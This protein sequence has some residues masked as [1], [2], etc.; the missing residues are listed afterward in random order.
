M[1]TTLP[2]IP[3]LVV[4]PNLTTEERKRY[5]KDYY[6]AHINKSRREEILPWPILDPMPTGFTDF[7][8]DPSVGTRSSMSAA[9]YKAALKAQRHAR[10]QSSAVI[11]DQHRADNP[12]YS[13]ALDDYRQRVIAYYREAG[14]PYYDMEPDDK[15][16]ELNKLLM[17]D[18][19]S[20]IQGDDVGQSMHGLSLAWVYFKHSWGVQC[21]KMKTAKEVFEDDALFEKAL[22]KR[23]KFGVYVS[24]SGVRKALRSFSGAQAVS[25][26]RPTAAAAIYD[27]FLS[28]VAEGEG[29]TW[30][31]SSGFGGRLLGAMA[32]RKVGTYIGTDPSTPTMNGLRD[33]E[34]ELLPLLYK[35]DPTRNPLKVELHQ[36]G[37]EDYNPEPE[38]ID[39]CFTS[40]PYFDTEKYTDEPTQSYIKFKGRDAW[41]NE[42]MRKTLDNC[43]KG[44][45]PNGHLVVNIADVKSYVTLNT[46]FVERAEKCGFKLVRRMNLLLSMMMGTRGKDPA[47]AARFKKEPIFVFKKA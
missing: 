23:M 11:Y 35:L 19:S 1:A 32:S 34:A 17:A 37:S 12:E 46:E 6:E 20:M 13:L 36:I 7:D 25:N 43:H 39:L 30:D 9:A 33:M 44:L 14:F 8:L 22:I 2:T 28:H 21:G 10:K 42:F 29:V 47:K 4:P 40:P 16:N 24:D 27:E 5:L 15:A 45:K 26:F 18:R 31:M 41:L 38:S 3:S